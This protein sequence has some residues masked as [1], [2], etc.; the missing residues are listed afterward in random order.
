VATCL[1]GW[2]QLGIRPNEQ[3]IKYEGFVGRPGWEA[4]GPNLLETPLNPALKHGR[5]LLTKFTKFTSS[6]NN[7]NNNNNK[8]I[9]M[10]P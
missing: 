4:W 6:D 2:Q 7:N 8:T 10:A 5:Q 3:E 1:G 9:S